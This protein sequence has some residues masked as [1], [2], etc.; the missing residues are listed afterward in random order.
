[1]RRGEGEKNAI[2]TANIF[3]LNTG[4]ILPIDIPNR[5]AVEGNFRIGE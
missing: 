1:M 4:K 2:V 3:N 5:N